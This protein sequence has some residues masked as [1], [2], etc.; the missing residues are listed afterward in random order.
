MHG[1]HPLARSFALLC[2]GSALGL[3]LIEWRDPFG[4]QVADARP[5]QAE[6]SFSTRIPWASIM[7]GR[8]PLG[9]RWRR[10]S[11]I[12]SDTHIV[13]QLSARTIDVYRQ[14]EVIKQYLVAIGQAEWETPEGTFQVIQTQEY[15]TWQHPITGEIIP[16]GKNNPLGSRWIGFLSSRDGEI[17][18]HGTNEERLIGEA[19]SH[20][21]VRMLNEDIEDLYTYVEIGTTVTVKR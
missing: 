13:L 7:A 15:P 6:N 12:Q 5:T 10:Q 4:W 21:C 14:G 1:L 18:F 11:A 19:V 17:G 9:G 3:A 20:G 16:A 2:V 8:R